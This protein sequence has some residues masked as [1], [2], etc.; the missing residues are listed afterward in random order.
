MRQAKL[1]S[2][3]GFILSLSCVPS[4]VPTSYLCQCQTNFL[5]RKHFFLSV[6]PGRKERRE[7]GRARGRQ[8]EKGGKASWNKMLCSLL[9]PSFFDL[10]ADISLS[11]AL[12]WKSVH[13]YAIT[14]WNL[15]SPNEETTS[16]N[17]N[18]MTFMEAIWSVWRPSI[19]PGVCDQVSPSEVCPWGFL[20]ITIGAIISGA[21]EYAIVHGKGDRRCDLRTERELKGWL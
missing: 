19:L 17:L 10:R 20:W 21:Y 18:K 3:I 9:K 14:C 7:G 11:I 8:D 13:S 5:P 1:L 2:F 16:F 15:D 12:E 4:A 6:F